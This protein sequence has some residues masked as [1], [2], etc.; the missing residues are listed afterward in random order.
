VPKSKLPSAGAAGNAPPL[1]ESLVQLAKLDDLYLHTKKYT[2]AAEKVI[3]A[4]AGAGGPRGF[5]FA[6]VWLPV[7]SRPRGRPRTPC[8]SWSRRPRRRSS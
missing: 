3:A 8:C 4:L 2:A 5:R 1:V 7:M 6:S